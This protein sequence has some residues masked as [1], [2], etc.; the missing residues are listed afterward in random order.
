MLYLNT[1]WQPCTKYDAQPMLPMG[2][3]VRARVC[4][5]MC[6]TCDSWLCSTGNTLSNVTLTIINCPEQPPTLPVKIL[7]P[8]RVSPDFCWEIHT[9]GASSATGVHV[10]QIKEHSFALE[11]RHRDTLMDLL[12]L[13]VLIRVLIIS[14]TG[15]NAV[16]STRCLWEIVSFCGTAWP[17]QTG[18]LT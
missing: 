9:Y 2:V 1:G 14:A 7:P 17:S 5:C 15:R 4:A 8:I 3:C 6:C 16:Q 12:L 10:H 11:H 13:S 18:T